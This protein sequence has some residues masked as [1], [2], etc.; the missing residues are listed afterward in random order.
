MRG[1][2]IDNRI[3]LLRVGDNPPQEFSVHEGVLR[4]H[5]A[6]FRAALDKKWR[7]GHSRQIDL[8]SDESDVVAAFVDWL[9]FRR[10]ASKPV[11]P[12]E[13]PMDDGEY[14]FLAG[15]YAFGDKVQANG[16]CDD[17]ISA[18]AMKTDD[19][20]EDGTRTFPGHSAIMKL[21]NGTPPGSPAR[22]FVVDMYAEFG[23]NQWIPK[24]PELNHPEFLTDLVYAFLERKRTSS[25]KVLNYPRRQKWHR[26]DGEF[27]RPASPRQ[28]DLSSF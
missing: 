2:T 22:R 27:L 19:V 8:P 25:H 5:S 17:V 1:S 4:E 24:E 11:S 26:R 18:M 23:M 28:Q 15:M 21:Y 9:Y 13:L 7:E 12:P 10:I 3:V 14:H 20:A 16:F 6:F